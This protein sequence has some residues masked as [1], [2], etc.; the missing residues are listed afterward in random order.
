MKKSVTPAPPTVNRLFSLSLTNAMRR[1]Q[2]FWSDDDA[3][4]R[5]H[6]RSSI[7]VLR[8]DEVTPGHVIACL[9]LHRAPSTEL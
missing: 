6:V 8:P 4:R 7:W 9:P 2:V 3:R 1:G 5:N